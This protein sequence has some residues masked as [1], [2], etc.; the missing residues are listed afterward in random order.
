MMIIMIIKMSKKNEQDRMY[1]IKM[2]IA[3]EK[4]KIQFLEQDS[5]DSEDSKVSEN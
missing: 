2:K 3:G 4:Q 5:R 1:D